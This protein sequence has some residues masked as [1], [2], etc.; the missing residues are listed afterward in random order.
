MTPFERNLEFWRQLWR[1]LERRWWCLGG[2]VGVCVVGVGV[3]VCRHVCVCVGDDVS[4]H[5]VMW[6][7]R[8]WMLETLSYSVVRIW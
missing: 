7:C 4:T 1:V 5:A 8:S 2:W 6:W 3:C